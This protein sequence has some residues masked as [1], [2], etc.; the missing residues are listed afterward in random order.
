V[1]AALQPGVALAWGSQG[2]EIVARLAHR[3]L[4]ASARHEVNGILGDVRLEAAATWAD[5]VRDDRP[6]TANWHFVD[7]PLDAAGYDQARDCR[8]QRKGDCVVRAIERCIEALRTG[9]AGCGG[10][11]REALQ[12]LIHFVA[13]VHQPLHCVDDHDRGGNEKHVCFFGVC[14]LGGNPLNLHGVWDSSLLARI[15]SDDRGSLARIE[16]RLGA[17]SDGERTAMAGGSVEDWVTES[18]A[19][20]RAA[21]RSLPGRDGRDVYHLDERYLDRH[22][23]VVD[24]QLARAALR[25]ARVLNELFDRSEPVNESRRGR[26]RGRAREGTA[27]QPAAR[28]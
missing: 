14:A 16:A 5:R 23:R 8:R 24:E 4:T 28:S 12:F 6:E 27:G 17:L 15:E 11:R 19:L 25:L 20:G 18:H 1:L 21:Y 3:R 13:D 7:V 10:S 2:H 22:A 9:A 26:F